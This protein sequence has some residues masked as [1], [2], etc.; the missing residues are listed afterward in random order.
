LV[1]TRLVNYDP[2]KN[3]GFSL[4]VQMIAKVCHLT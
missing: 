2:K 3:G 4:N 1:R